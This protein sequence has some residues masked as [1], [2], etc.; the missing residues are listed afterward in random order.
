MTNIYLKLG[1]SLSVRIISSFVKWG[2]EREAGL[3]Q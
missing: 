2:G 3:G 1:D